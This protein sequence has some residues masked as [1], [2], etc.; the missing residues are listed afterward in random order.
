MYII[1]EHLF[2]HS[3]IYHGGE[4]SFSYPWGS[5][6]HYKSGKNNLVSPD[7]NAMSEVANFLV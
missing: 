1:K 6:N 7:N 5:Y 3:I 2:V 4:T